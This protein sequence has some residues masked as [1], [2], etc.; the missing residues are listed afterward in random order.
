MPQEITLKRGE[1]QQLVFWTDQTYSELPE[2]TTK[3][4]FLELVNANNQDQVEATQLPFIQDYDTTEDD[5]DIEE[6]L[7]TQTSQIDADE[8]TEASNNDAMIDEYDETTVKPEFTTILSTLE[9]EILDD[10]EYVFQEDFG[11]PINAKPT[12]IEDPLDDIA[13]VVNEVQVPPEVEFIEVH[14]DDTTSSFDE[15]ERL[16]EHTTIAFPDEKPLFE[17]VVAEVEDQSRPS[18][19]AEGLLIDTTTSKDK[20]SEQRP[21]FEAV[22]S[23]DY[24][25]D[26]HPQEKPLF[27]PIVAED[28]DEQ[29]DLLEGKPLFE[30]IVA[31]DYDNQGDLL[32]GKPLFEPIVA[33]DYDDQGDLLEGKPL[34]E[35]IVAEVEEE[36]AATNAQGLLIDTTTSKD[37]LIPVEAVVAEEEPQLDANGLLVETTTGKPI[38]RVALVTTQALEKLP[39]GADED[40]A[41]E[42][43]L[44]VL[45]TTEAPDNLVVNITDP[46]DVSI[47]TTLIDGFLLQKQPAAAEEIPVT[48]KP[49]TAGGFPVTNILSGIYNL[50]SSYIQPSEE[51]EEEPITAIPQSAINVHNMPRDQLIVEAAEES[52]AAPPLP[53]LPTEFLR[54]TPIDIQPKPKVPSP[55]NISGP[56]LILNENGNKTREPVNIPLPDLIGNDPNPRSIELE[57]SDRASGQGRFRQFVDSHPDPIKQRF[58]FKRDAD[59]MED[60]TVEPEAT[61]LS[62]DEIVDCSWSIKV[63]FRFKF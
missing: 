59:D 24:D 2:T 14:D 63:T 9:D 5:F 33:E 60:V 26:L 39:R 45:G 43:N 4:Y 1:R 56:L 27:Q 28:Y 22:V 34:F 13:D 23:E 51:E 47:L 25:Y 44:Q 32:E 35:P 61:T 54:G 20:L 17:P 21:S 8:T 57:E 30:P 16:F 42:D 19:T 46:S 15:V 49:E 62:P 58:I 52:E 29:G 3:D 18:T 48:D 38:N 37:I 7:T 53:V 40:F 41:I 31:E 10:D 55:E 12:A 11:T 6:M 50:V 36:S